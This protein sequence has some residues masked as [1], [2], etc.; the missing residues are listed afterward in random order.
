MKALFTVAAVV[1]VTQMAFA[2]G[3][4]KSTADHGFLILAQH[5]CKSFGK[6]NH[7]SAHWDFRTRTCVCRG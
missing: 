1:F 3:A 2:S 4:H 6:A 7:C 5:G